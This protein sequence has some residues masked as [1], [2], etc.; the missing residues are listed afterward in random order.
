MCTSYLCN[1][2]GTS[3]LLSPNHLM[4]DVH[5]VCSTDKDFCEHKSKNNLRNSTEMP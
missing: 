4:D 1:G 2:V 5:N 3:N